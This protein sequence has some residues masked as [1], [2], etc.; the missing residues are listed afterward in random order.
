MKN[1]RSQPMKPGDIVFMSANDC[2][3]IAPGWYKIESFDHEHSR[4]YP[5]V[6]W[7]WNA[8]RLCDGMMQTIPENSEWLITDCVNPP[9]L[10]ATYT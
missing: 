7:W 4:E 10:G 1:D 3:G 2:E 9:S 5:D 8:R 6:G